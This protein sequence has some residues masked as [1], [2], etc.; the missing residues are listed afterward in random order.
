MVAL[1]N[2]TGKMKK[3]K[4]KKSR[5]KRLCQSS[6]PERPYNLLLLIILPTAKTLLREAKM[7]KKNPLMPYSTRL[8]ISLIDMVSL[9]FLFV[10]P[11]GVDAA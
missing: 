4:S 10:F 2:Q 11:L 9:L 1:E 5:L 8:I 6:W 7:P 3:A